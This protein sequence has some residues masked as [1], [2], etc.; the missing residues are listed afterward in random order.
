MD[1]EDYQK[2]KRQK[3]NAGAD[4]T[5]PSIP[6]SEILREEVATNNAEKQFEI[7]Q[8]LEPDSTVEILPKTS[9]NLDLA[10]G[11]GEDVAGSGKDS[12]ELDGEDAVNSATVDFFLAAVPDPYHAKFK[13][14]ANAIN[15][16]SYKGGIFTLDNEEYSF[17]VLKEIINTLYTPV[18][19]LR[20]NGEDPEF[21]DK[22]AAFVNSLNNR[23]LRNYVKN[24]SYTFKGTFNGVSNK[25]KNWYQF[26]ADYDFV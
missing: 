1:F 16:T 20:S 15:L 23:K 8:S 3:S 10:E 7:N 17:N 2:L 5:L 13:K 18:K 11:E 6:K 21:A 12:N 25:K 14:L 19:A 22:F 24:K 4:E 9:V 26:N